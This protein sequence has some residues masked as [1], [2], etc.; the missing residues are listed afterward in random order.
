[1]DKIVEGKDAKGANKG[2]WTS[3]RGKWLDAYK[4]EETSS[5]NVFNSVENDVNVD[6]GLWSRGASGIAKQD[7]TKDDSPFDENSIKDAFFG[8]SKL[9]DGSV[10]GSKAEFQFPSSP[11]DDD[12]APDPS[13]TEDSQNIYLTFSGGGHSLDFSSSVS[14]LID[15]YGY[16]WTFSDDALVRTNYDVSGGASWLT[17]AFE[18]HDIYGKVASIE[19]AMVLEKHGDFEVEYSLGDNDP[20]DKFIIHVS[21]D[22]HFGTPLFRTIGSA[23][24]CQG[25]P[26]TMWRENRMILET[27]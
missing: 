5:K 22:K 16:S 27:D 11:S 25:E 26:N 10:F 20:F 8:N 18:Y 1:M 15:S 9:I 14:S 13:P 23:S 3:D 19:R 12:P 2:N 6:E 17:A 7:A 21:S 24:K 4:D